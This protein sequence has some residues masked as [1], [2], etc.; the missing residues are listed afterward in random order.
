MQIRVLTPVLVGLYLCACA[1]GVPLRERAQTEA[2]E[3]LELSLS[4]EALAGSWTNLGRQGAVRERA[5]VLGLGPTMRTEWIDWFSFQRNVVIELPGRSER[6]I[7]VVA[8]YDKTDVN[9]FKLA[10][11][12]VNGLLDELAGFTFSLRRR[13]RQRHG[14]GGCAARGGGARRA[15]E[16]L[17]LPD[18]P[19]RLRGVGAARGAG[20]HCAPVEPSFGLSLRSFHYLQQFR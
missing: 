19:Q 14:N 5:A 17:L 4:I 15:G 8:H 12:L 18:P 2:P 11:M 7:Y 1:S 9:P 16:P 10:S 20:A 13:S 6:T 3:A